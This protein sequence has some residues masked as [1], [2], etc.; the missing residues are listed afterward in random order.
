MRGRSER[1]HAGMR[2]V[3]VVAPHFTDRV[4]EA[5]A[6]VGNPAQTPDLRDVDR[7]LLST[8]LRELTQAIGR[9]NAAEQ[10]LHGE[11]HPA[12]S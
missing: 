9:R 7:E 5:Q 11:P 2:Q 3:D 1:L 10:L 6:L 12:T 8:T 4:A